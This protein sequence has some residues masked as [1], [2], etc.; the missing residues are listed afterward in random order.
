[1]PAVHVGKECG[2]NEGS[3]GRQ[4]RVQR[5]VAPALHVPV[6]GLEW[7][8]VCRERSVSGKLVGRRVD[9]SWKRC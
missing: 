4:C 3:L 6:L 7:H 8:N 1:M 5:Q 9:Q 2:R